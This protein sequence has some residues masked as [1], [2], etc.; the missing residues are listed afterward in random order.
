MSTQWM[1]DLRCVT[2][3]EK[4]PGAIE[5]TRAGLLASAGLA[6]S[7]YQARGYR[8]NSE[9]VIEESAGP[10]KERPGMGVMFLGYKIKLTPE[11]G[12]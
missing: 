10:D 8:L 3:P 1:A 4:N 12:S 7:E 6:I 9:V 2:D 11:G 5:E